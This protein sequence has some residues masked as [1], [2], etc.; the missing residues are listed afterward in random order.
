MGIWDINGIPCI[1][2]RAED[3][4]YPI[5]STNP[6]RPPHATTLPGACGKVLTVDGE[7]G[8]PGVS[9]VRSDWGLAEWRRIWMNIWQRTWFLSFFHASDPTKSLLRNFFSPL[10]CSMTTSLK[11]YLC[12]EGVQKTMFWGH[13]QATHRKNPEWTT[14]AWSPAR[15]MNGSWWVWMIHHHSSHIS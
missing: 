3:L 6:P 10:R 14:R 1:L 12:Q 15:C 7:E 8:V 5:F 11:K 9:P 4:G 2:V 13:R